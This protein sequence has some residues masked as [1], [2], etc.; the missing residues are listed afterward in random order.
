MNINGLLHHLISKK[1]LQQD[2][3]RARD[4]YDVELKSTHSLSEITDRC[5]YISYNSGME[6]LS[7]YLSISVI[8][9]EQQS[10]FR[11]RICH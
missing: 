2:A 11:D 5:V 10:I 9:I 6:I 8:H 4:K 7:I 3:Y 1:I